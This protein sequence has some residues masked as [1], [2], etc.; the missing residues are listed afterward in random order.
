MKTARFP[1][2]SPSQVRSQE[3]VEAVLDA[4]AHTFSEH[5]FAA[6]T[7]NSIAEKAGV[8]IGSLYQYFPN[9]L[10]ILEALR[11]RHVKR[12][13][14]A[15]GKACDKSHELPWPDAL[16]PTIEA[17][18][19]VNRSQHKLVAI[20]NAELPY[21]MQETQRLLIARTNYIDRY[22]RFLIAHKDSIKVDIDHALFTLPALG[23][24]FF[25]AVANERPE[26]LRTGAVVDKMLAVMLGYLS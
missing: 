2:K 11:E 26:E 18:I 13:W 24:G 6:A 25:S 17:A 21:M 12:L 3:T 9:K 5:G 16:R 22:R 8:S 19:E 7:T 10:A 14:E 23:R 15:I 4:A 20:M 1:R